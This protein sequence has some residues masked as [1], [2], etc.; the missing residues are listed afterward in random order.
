MQTFTFFI[1]AVTCCK[2]NNEK[3]DLYFVNIVTELSAWKLLQGNQS[4]QSGYIKELIILL[5]SGS[6]VSHLEVVHRWRS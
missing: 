5:L 6:S 4:E 3:H 2:T 1:W